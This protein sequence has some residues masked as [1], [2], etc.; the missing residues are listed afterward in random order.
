MAG[1]VVE[2]KSIICYYA[3]RMAKAKRMKIGPRSREAMA[4]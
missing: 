4:H 3:E 2:F 1:I